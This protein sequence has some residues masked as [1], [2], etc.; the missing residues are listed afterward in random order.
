MY[1]LCC[2][3]CMQLPWMPPP[4]P[5]AVE[6]GSCVTRP[7]ASVEWQYRPYAGTQ[8]LRK[9]QRAER[10]GSKGG[11]SR[12]SGSCSSSAG[13]RTIHSHGKWG[14]MN[15]AHMVLSS[16]AMQKTHSATMIS[17]S[18]Q[19][20]PPQIRPT[21]SAAQLRANQIQTDQLQLD[22]LQTVQLQAAQPRP[23]QIQPACTV[24]SVGRP[25]AYNA[26]RALAFAQANMEQVSG[27]NTLAFQVCVHEVCECAWDVCAWGL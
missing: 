16:I 12:S 7:E 3:Y 15:L 23:D 24:R 26:V 22:Q 13:P 9:K 21:Q 4:L 11:S 14:Y 27:R 8:K 19:L 10:Q 1:C 2:L 6:D 20:Q 17:Y 25:P 18:D 5:L